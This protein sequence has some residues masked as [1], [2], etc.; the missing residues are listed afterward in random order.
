MLGFLRRNCCTNLSPVVQC[1]LFVALMR[2]HLR[3]ASLQL[4]APCYSASIFLMRLIERVERRAF[5]LRFILHVLDLDYKAWLIHLKL[6][7]LSYFLEYLDLLFLFCCFKGEILLDV[8]QF[9]QFSYSSTR[10]GSPGLDLCLIPIC[11]AL[12]F[13]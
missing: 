5:F 7:R 1:S 3:Y 8:T 10:C 11:R 6:L 9:V 12:Y 4:W 13:P 2:S